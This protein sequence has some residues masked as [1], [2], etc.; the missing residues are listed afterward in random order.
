[1]K[2]SELLHAQLHGEVTTTLPPIASVDV[3]VCTIPTDGPEADGTLDWSDTTM[4]IAELGAGTETGFGWS[5]A[6]AGAAAVIARQLRPAVIGIDAGDIPLA[7]SAMTNAVRNV[8]R[9][10]VSGCAIAVVDVALWDL[11]AKLLETSVVGLLGRARDAVAAY[12]SGGFC[13]YSLRRLRDQLH[14]WVSDGMRMVKMKVGRDAAADI[15]RVATVRQA[16]GEHA[17]IFVDAN[18]AYSRQQALRVADAFSELGVTWFE[19]PVSSD[20]LDGLRLLRDRSPAGMDIA[21]GEYGWTAFDVRRMLDAQAV[22]VLQIDATRCG[23]FT[24][25]LRAAALC[26]AACVPTSAHTSPTLHAHVACCTAGTRHVEY[27]YDHSRVEQMLVDGALTPIDGHLRPDPDRPGLG[28][29][30]KWADVKDF[31]V[32]SSR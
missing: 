9:P 6:S 30:V 2:C 8:G 11:K 29:E 4:V 17:E 15:R 16:I 5:Y 32:W 19:E 23:G 13:T 31:L 25:Y 26:E 7:E 24:G 21:A 27:F 18:G 14:G 3:H 10:G 12:G 28:V 22:D 20:D 1:M